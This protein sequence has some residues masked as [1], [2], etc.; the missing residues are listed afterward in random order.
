[1]NTSVLGVRLP[2]GLGSPKVL[3]KSSNADKCLCGEGTENGR[4]DVFKGWRR[5]VFSL[6]SCS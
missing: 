3:W 2:T 1:M 4:E 6:V 5:F